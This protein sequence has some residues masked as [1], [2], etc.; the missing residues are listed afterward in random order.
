VVSA[1]APAS[2]VREIGLSV[3]RV[4][5]ALAFLMSGGAKLVGVPMMVQLFA[6]IGIGQWFRYVTGGLEVLGAVALLLPA[7]AGLGALLLVLVMIGAV[8]THLFVIGGNPS[9]AMVLLVLTSI[10]AWG[11]RDRTM[12]LIGNFLKRRD[13]WSMR[14]TIR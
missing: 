8:G 4:L 10:I 9:H 14:R 13:R 3:L 5:M 12:R 6:Q 7:L 1:P 11:R 2:R